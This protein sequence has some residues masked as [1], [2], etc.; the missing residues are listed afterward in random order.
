MNQIYGEKSELLMKIFE[1]FPSYKNKSYDELISIQLDSE[2]IERLK[3]P[4]FREFIKN[5]LK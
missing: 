1:K 3:L 5:L 2:L 4:I